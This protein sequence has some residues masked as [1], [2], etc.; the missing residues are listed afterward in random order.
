MMSMEHVS[1]E[2]IEEHS[3]IVVGFISQT[4]WVVECLHRMSYIHSLGRGSTS[5]SDVAPSRMTVYSALSTQN[6]IANFHLIQKSLDI[7]DAASD[8]LHPP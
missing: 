8:E 4:S 2:S 7:E 1:T 3:H 6:L 5:R